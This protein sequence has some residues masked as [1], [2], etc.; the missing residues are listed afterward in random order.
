MPLVEQVTHL[1]LLLLRRLMFYR[2]F[3]DKFIYFLCLQTAILCE[4]VVKMFYVVFLCP[5][6]LQ[7]TW[8]KFLFDFTGERNEWTQ[9]GLQYGWA[10]SG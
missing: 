8:S 3:T 7:V 2:V 5:F 6:R 1:K 9:W 4:K 10:L